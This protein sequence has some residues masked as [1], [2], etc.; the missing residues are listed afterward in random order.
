MMSGRFIETKHEIVR[1]YAIFWRLFCILFATCILSTFFVF[2]FL[3][4]RV[5]I[6]EF[7]RLFRF[8]STRLK[9]A[10]VS[11][12]YLYGDGG[13]VTNSNFLYDSSIGLNMSVTLNGVE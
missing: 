5:F 9:K 2:F 8:T 10:F 4:V 6:G 3:F 1:N 11:N 13:L 12:A 7:F